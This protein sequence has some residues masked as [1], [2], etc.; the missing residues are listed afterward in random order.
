MYYSTSV[1]CSQH[2]NKNFSILSLK[3]H[4]Q[5][6]VPG[7]LHDNKLLCPPKIGAG[8]MSNH[9]WKWSDIHVLSMVTIWF[10]VVVCAYAC[11]SEG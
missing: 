3:I 10:S 9:F 5:P 4:S 7:N 8:S 1:Y 6:I 11:R 2:G